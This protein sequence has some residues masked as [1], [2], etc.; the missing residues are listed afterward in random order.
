MKIADYQLLV[1]FHTY[2]TIRQTAKKVLISQPALTQRL[3]YIETQMEGKIFLRTSKRLIPTP[4]GEIVLHHAGEVLKKERNF[5][6]K[7][8]AVRGKITGT[9]SIG[10]SSLYSQYFLPELLQSFTELYP[11]VTIDL[12]TGVSDE[13][14]QTSDSYH[15]SIVRGEPIQDYESLHLISD[16]LYLIDVIPFSDEKERPFIEFKS[17]PD[18]QKLIERWMIGQPPTFKRLIKIDHFETAKQ[19][20]MRG[21]GMTVLPESIIKGEKESFEFVPLEEDGQAI[22]RETWACMREGMRTLPQVDAFMKHLEKG[23][24]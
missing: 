22:V 4:L 21:L 5:R 15:V 24:Q 6:E 19:M 7:L 14:R 1:D 23:G 9:I 3:K 18:F 13:I 12:V 16:P 10:A 8:S 2:G 17:D 11:D 20:M